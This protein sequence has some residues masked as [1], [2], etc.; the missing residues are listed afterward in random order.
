[1]KN[2][3]SFIRREEKLNEEFI[4]KIFGKFWDKLGKIVGNTPGGDEIE[5][6][7]KKYQV[8]LKTELEKIA[9][10]DLQAA[11]A[12]K[13]SILFNY[14]SFINEDTEIESDKEDVQASTEKDKT[15]TKDALLKKSQLLN[16]KLELVLKQAS[17]D[18]DKVLKKK[19]GAEKNDKLKELIELKKDTLKMDFL[20]MR[21][22]YIEDSG[23]KEEIKKAQ[24]ERNN[25]N[26]EIESRFNKINAM[27]QQTTGG[28]EGEFKVGNR[29]QYKTEGEGIKNIE[30]TGPGQ[31]EGEVM[32]KYLHPDDGKIEPQSFTTDNIIKNPE[33]T[34][35]VTYGY[36]SGKG[37]GDLI[38]VIVK[39]EPQNGMVDVSSENK[40]DETFKVDINLLRPNE[41]ETP[42]TEETPKKQQKT[43]KK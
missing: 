29:Y 31:K 23:D 26:K 10:I 22:A 18:M 9:G 28:E 27:G 13:E 15:L 17:R 12:K 8:L 34:S 6:I 4:G 41:Q 35:G 7:Y 24:I 2:Y 25:K 3:E 33:I 14:K 21:L 30:I 1:M 39:G 16:Q 42:K 38:N 5:K 36:R 40:P 43:K 37:T 19:G 20:N 11:S 32:A